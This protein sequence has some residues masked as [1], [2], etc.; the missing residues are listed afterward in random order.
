MLILPL[1]IQYSNLSLYL[2]FF[3]FFFLLFFEGTSSVTE[4]TPKLANTGFKTKFQIKGN[5]F[6]VTSKTVDFKFYLP[7]G[8]I[9]K[10]TGNVINDKLLE[11]EYNFPTETAN[12]VTNFEYSFDDGNSFTKS[13][14]NIT[15]FSEN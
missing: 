10:T 11:F 4:I 8:T 5:N 13:N 9:I 12:G 14:F 1:F 15:L 7:G 2:V 6:V 3:F